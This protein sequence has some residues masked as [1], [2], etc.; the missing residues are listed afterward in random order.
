MREILKF[1]G[2]IVLSALV[3]A[4]LGPFGLVLGLIVVGAMACS[5]RSPY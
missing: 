4:A 5:T 3:V 2:M 1:Y